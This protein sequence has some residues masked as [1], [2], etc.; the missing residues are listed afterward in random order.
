MQG[1]PRIVAILAVIG[2]MAVGALAIGQHSASAA[3]FPDPATDEPAASTPGS[4]KAVF[5]GGCFWGIQA[6]FEHVKGV[7]KATA[8]YAGGAADK[9]HYEIVSTGTTGHAESVEVVF[10]P[11]VVTYGQLL[12][13]FFHVAHDPTELNRQ[14]PDEGTQYRSAVWVANP[15]QDKI[16]K[17]YIAQLDAAK[18]FDGKIVTQVNPLNAFYA[19][20][21]YHQDYLV[22]HPNQ[23]YIVFNDLPKLD[24]LKR[25]LPELWV[26][27]HPAS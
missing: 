6:V 21:G 14:G 20:E 11:S 13:V 10:D 24:D 7:T 9:A 5:S 18:V 4:E 2:T 23:P 19:A 8:G 25:A 3:G 22:H 26:E 1:M 16:A 27:Y 12:K 17:G 15:D